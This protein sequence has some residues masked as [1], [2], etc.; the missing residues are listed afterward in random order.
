MI[1]ILIVHLLF[2][3]RNVYL[4]FKELW[5]YYSYFWKLW[6]NYEFIVINNAI[7]NKFFENLLFIKIFRYLKI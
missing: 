6:L 5:L 1:I 4:I 2:C 3:V 7:I